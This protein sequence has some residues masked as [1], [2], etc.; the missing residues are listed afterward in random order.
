MPNRR[1]TVRGARAGLLL[2]ALLGLARAWCSWRLRSSS[3]GC[4]ARLA[5]RDTRIEH[6]FRGLAESPQGR[7]P[8]ASTRTVAPRWIRWIAAWV[9]ALGF[10]SLALILFGYFNSEPDQA[11]PRGVFSSS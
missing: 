8:K 2:L 9:L 3:H 5:A 1:G 7:G 11:P 6:N 4:S 10:G